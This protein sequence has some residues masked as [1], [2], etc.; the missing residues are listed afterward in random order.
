MGRDRDTDGND[1]VVK[2]ETTFR[3]FD[4]GKLSGAKTSESGE[5]AVIG[6]F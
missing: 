4:L 2:R 3:V 6:V 1:R 5:E